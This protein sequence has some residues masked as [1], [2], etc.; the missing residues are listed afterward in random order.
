MTI[1]FAD[2]D[3]A[4]G[5]WVPEERTVLVDRRLSEREVAEVIEH[6]LGHVAIDDQHADLDAGVVHPPPGSSRRWAAALTAAACLAVVGGVTAGLAR[7][8]RGAIKNGPVVAPSA[9]PLTA[10]PPGPDEVVA[11]RVVIGP[12]GQ[13]LVHTVTL[14][15]THGVTTT[16]VTTAGPVVPSVTRSVPAAPARSSTPSVTIPAPTTSQPAATSPPPPATTA[17]TEVPSPPAGTEAPQVD[18]ASVAGSGSASVQP[19]G[20]P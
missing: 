15:G 4:D 20:M 16:A 14:T 6:E 1:C 19:S 8:D 11:T 13:I 18:D 2:L 10:A 3:G 17:T 9:P 12:E 5:L 7:V